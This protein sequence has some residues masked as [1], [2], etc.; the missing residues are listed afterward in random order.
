MHGYFNYNL[1]CVEYP[2][3]GLLKHQRV[4]ADK[5]Q[6]AVH[7]FMSHIIDY[8]KVNPKSII[9]VG[10]SIG[11]GFAAYIT[12]HVNVRCLVMVSAF[13]SIK[14]VAKDMVGGMMAML[15]KDILRTEDNIRKVKCPVLLIHGK[16]DKLISHKHSEQL[17]KL[18]KHKVKQ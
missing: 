7:C 4:G 16:E 17:I 15:V 6:A 2:G 12:S 13:L 18:V 14:Q 9:V 1:Y 11:T 5:T 3:Y 10:K 8:N